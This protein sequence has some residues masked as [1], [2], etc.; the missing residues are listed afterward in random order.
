LEEQAVLTRN[1]PAKKSEENNEEMT[2][3]TSMITLQQKSMSA[4]QG[5]G[6]WRRLLDI[7]PEVILRGKK[8]GFHDSSV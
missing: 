7:F 1:T 3:K 5:T 2:L 8:K 6:C 4:L